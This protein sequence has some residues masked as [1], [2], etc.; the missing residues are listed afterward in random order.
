MRSLGTN[1]IL[2]AGSAWVS[3][4]DIREAIKAYAK[5]KDVRPE[6]TVEFTGTAK[7]FNNLNEQDTS[8]PFEAQIFIKADYG[9]PSEQFNAAS[10]GTVLRELLTNHGEV[11]AMDL[12][13]ESPPVASYR[14]EFYS[15]VSVDPA[16]QALNGFK[17]AVSALLTNLNN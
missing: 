7:Y 8:L 17:I 4:W 14:A 15:S 9:G 13:E 12:V 5:V 11:M 1:E 16:L 2:L 6:W 10:I 3:F